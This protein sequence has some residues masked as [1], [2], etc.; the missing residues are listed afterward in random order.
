MDEFSSLELQPL[1][2]LV[3]PMKP[4]SSREIWRQRNIQTILCAT[5]VLSLQ[6]DFLHLLKYILDVPHPYHDTIL[7]RDFGA[8]IVD[9]ETFADVL[10]IL[11]TFGIG[12]ATSLV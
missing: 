8:R 6:V 11:C 12:R 9:A 1:A 3:N 4:E 7:I 10:L 5:F 2:L